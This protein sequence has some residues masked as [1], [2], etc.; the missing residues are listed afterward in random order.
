MQ[1]DCSVELLLE[2]MR[3]KQAKYRT[4]TRLV[5]LLVCSVTYAVLKRRLSFSGEA[6][7]SACTVR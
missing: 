6:E 4:H 2:G 5:L 7:I 1:L 3:G